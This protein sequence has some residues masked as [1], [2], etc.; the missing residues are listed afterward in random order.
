MSRIRF[1]RIALVVIGIVLLCEAGRIRQFLK[2]LDLGGILT[3]EPL[4]RT[5]ESGR[6]LVTIALLALAFVTLDSLLRRR[7]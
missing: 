3:L 1:K 2:G 4:R 7:K 5:P 6:F